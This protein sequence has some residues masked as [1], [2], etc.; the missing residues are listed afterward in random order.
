MQGTW[1]L[2]RLILFANY[3]G[4]GQSTSST[5]PGNVLNQTL[6]TFSFGFGLSSR[7]ARVRP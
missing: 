7:E 2:G 5:L 1:Q 6:N 3:T 4:T